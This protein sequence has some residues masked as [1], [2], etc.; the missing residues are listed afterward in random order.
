MVLKKGQTYTHKWN[1]A[2]SKTNTYSQFCYN[3]CF[4]NANLFPC[5]QYIRKQFKLNMN[6]S[7]EIHVEMYAKLPLRNTRQNTR[8]LHLAEASQE[9]MHTCTHLEHLPA[10]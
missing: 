8:K 9:E 7:F 1:R 4:E 10:I 5:K 3:A 6:L 2:V